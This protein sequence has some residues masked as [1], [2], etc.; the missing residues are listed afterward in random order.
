M[1]IQIYIRYLNREI[2]YKI[3]KLFL[4]SYLIWKKFV[5]YVIFYLY[6]LLKPLSKGESTKCYMNQ[7]FRLYILDFR[8]DWKISYCWS[9]DLKEQALALSLQII[10]ILPTSSQTSSTSFGNP[11]LLLRQNSNSGVL[12]VYWSNTFNFREFDQ[13]WNDRWFFLDFLPSLCLFYLLAISPKK[14]V[15]ENST[16]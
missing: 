14:Q 3:W 2:V 15:Q 1:Y 4:F 10:K 13:V 6:K 12:D 5:Q 16:L 11:T 8:L 7:G 9:K